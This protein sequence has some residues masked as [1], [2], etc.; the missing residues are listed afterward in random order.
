LR[1]VPLELCLSPRVS[2][3]LTSAVPLDPE[4]PEFHR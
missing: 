3:T 1:G 2:C 4:R